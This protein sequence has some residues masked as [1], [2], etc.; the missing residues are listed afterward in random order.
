M[1]RQ[2]FLAAVGLV[3]GLGLSAMPAQ[4]QPARRIL[5]AEDNG[6]NQ[7]LIKAMLDHLG[8]YSDVV[9]DGFEAVRQVQAAHYDLVLMDIQMPGMD[10]VAATRAIRTLPNSVSHIPI[11]AM[12]ANAMVEER[13]AYLAAGMND[14]VAKPLD[15]GRLAAVI[16]RV[17]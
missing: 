15:L 3:V 5:V 4:A 6:V 12:T 16:S 17:S 1:G 11:V 9:A 14:H 8:H 2:K 7:I 13:A 10:G